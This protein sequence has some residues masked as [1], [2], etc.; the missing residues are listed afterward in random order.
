MHAFSAFMVFLGKLM[1]L[2]ILAL[3]LFAYG[4]GAVLSIQ[5]SIMTIILALS[6]GFSADTVTTGLSAGIAILASYAVL[7]II[8][9]LGDILRI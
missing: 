7:L 5:L 1:T 4:I 6:E 8:S 2:L 9:T 3:V